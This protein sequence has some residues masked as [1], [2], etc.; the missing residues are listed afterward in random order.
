MPMIVG[1]IMSFGWYS[2]IGRRRPIDTGDDDGTIL[3]PDGSSLFSIDGS[4][5]NLLSVL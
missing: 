1:I 5:E 3:S 4:S 2:I